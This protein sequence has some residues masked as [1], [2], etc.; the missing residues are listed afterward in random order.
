M[1]RHF[2]RSECVSQFRHSGNTQ[3]PEA[4]GSKMCTRSEEVAL[5]GA[6]VEMSG[7]TK[8]S[9]SIRKLLADSGRLARRTCRESGIPVPQRLIENLCGTFA[10]HCCPDTPE[11][12]ESTR[13]TL[14]KHCC[15][16]TPEQLTESTLSFLG[17]L[18]QH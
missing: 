3:T 2:S 4:G 8:D 7:G 15:A 11:Q 10:E 13:E 16:D 6:L 9:H 12:F 17:V 5:V 14:A 18:P 1:T